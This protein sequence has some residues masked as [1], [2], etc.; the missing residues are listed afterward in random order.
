MTH[1]A[2][3]DH[4]TTDPARPARPDSASWGYGHTSLLFCATGIGVLVVVFSN[5]YSSPITVGAIAWL[6]LSVTLT[7]GGLQGARWAFGR[8]RSVRV[9]ST[10]A[11]DVAAL[12]HHAIG[13][14]TKL[15]EWLD[16]EKSQGE[17]SK[18]ARERLER[19]E[20]V[21]LVVSGTLK[22]AAVFGDRLTVIEQ[23]MT[24]LAR[25]IRDATSQQSKEAS[26]IEVRLDSL[27]KQLSDALAMLGAM[28]LEMPAKDEV[29]AELREQ[30]VP[31]LRAEVKAA[32]KAEKVAGYLDDVRGRLAGGGPDLHVVRPIG[33]E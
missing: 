30:V 3:T 4:T 8:Q 32:V 20:R 28:S 31:E 10:F 16:A 7:L 33:E 12:E 19:V 29:V 24:A 17:R 9:E 27:G 26:A 23:G 14:A 5:A 11:E 22:E 2:S 1:S 18:E 6:A 13:T 15:Q 21:L 25:A